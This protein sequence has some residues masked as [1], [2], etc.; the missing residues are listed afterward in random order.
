MTH[1]YNR[2]HI[3]NTIQRRALQIYKTMYE[4]NDVEHQLIDY[5]INHSECDQISHRNQ[6]ANILAFIMVHKICGF[7]SSEKVPRKTTNKLRYVFRNLNAFS[8]V[9]TE[10]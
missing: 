2:V 9:H 1:L 3:L 10:C 4:L 5:G 8:R 7:V 6:T